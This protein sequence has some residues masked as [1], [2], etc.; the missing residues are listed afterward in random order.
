MRCADSLVHKGKELRASQQECADLR[1]QSHTTAIEL[2]D[3]RRKHD[4][5]RA[6]R[7]KA[8]GE[9]TRLRHEVATERARTEQR[10]SSKAKR[11]SW[12]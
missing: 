11:G 9:V 2:A 12:G 5:E 8:E 7:T 4:E 6:R 3:A 1:M 10:S